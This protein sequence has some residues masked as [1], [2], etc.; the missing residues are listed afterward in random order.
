MTAQA[1]R[2]TPVG[3][4]TSRRAAL[5]RGASFAALWLVLLPSAQ[6]ED[7]VLGALTA[8]ASTGVSLR[9][10][11]PDAGRV[12][13][14]ALLALGPRFLWQSVAAGID[15]ARRAFAPRMPLEP[16][17]L[18]YP[19]GL[20]RGPVRSAFTTITCLVPGTVASGE[21]DTGT[22]YHCLDSSQPVLDQL[23]NE[24]RAYAKAL[25]PGRTR[26]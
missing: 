7:L 11:P 4:G 16:G 17:L 24:E 15:V 20:P 19:A 10:L 18:T 5:A 23:R 12:R 13:L 8:L 2:D 9:L 1:Q 14:L 21:D 25:V 26:V 3:T 22:V 6:P